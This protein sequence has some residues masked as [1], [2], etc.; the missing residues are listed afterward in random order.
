MHSLTNKT[1]S[2][3]AQI[4]DQLDESIK[5]GVRPVL[6]TDGTSGTYLMRD[7]QSDCLL[8]VFKPV[9][10]EQFAPNNP[11]EYQGEFGSNTLRG[12]VKSGEATIREVAACLIDRDGFSGV[13]Q[14]CLVQV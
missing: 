9:D 13:P 11:R 4:I 2:G 14:T 5:A 10:E 1:P 8:A 3:L 12:G 6:T 7:K